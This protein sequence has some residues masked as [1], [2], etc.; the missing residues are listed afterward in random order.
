MYGKSDDRRTLNY[1][2]QYAKWNE[3]TIH[4]WQLTQYYNYANTFDKIYDQYYLS[5]Q[6]YIILPYSFDVNI[7]KNNFFSVRQH[8]KNVLNV[9]N[10]KLLKAFVSDLIHHVNVNCEMVV[11]SVSE[12]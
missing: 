6:Y 4:W 2:K 7:K 8:T 1:L 3:I 10:I 11:G 5:I 12:R 9:L